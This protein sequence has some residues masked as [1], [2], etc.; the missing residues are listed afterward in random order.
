MNILLS[1]QTPLKRISLVFSSMAALSTQPLSS[2]HFSDSAKLS[3]VRQWQIDN[4]QPL[5]ILFYWNSPNTSY[6]WQIIHPIMNVLE[7]ILSELLDHSQLWR[8]VSHI[9]Y[10]VCSKRPGEHRSRKCSHQW[11]VLKRLI[12]ATS[13]VWLNACHNFCPLLDPSLT[14]FSST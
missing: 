8:M 6:P 11:F 14:N 2:A 13:H 1:P 5:Q 4:L 3:V 7:L 10:Q 12:S 9:Q